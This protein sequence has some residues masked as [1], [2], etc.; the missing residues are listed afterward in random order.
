[1]LK[2]ILS[3]TLSII[4]CISILSSAIYA[5]AGGKEAA[6]A[7]YSLGLF[8]GIGNSPD[9]TPVYE[10]HRKPTRAEAITMLIR[11]LGKE[12]EA[13]ENI[14]P[15]PFTDV[16]DW[17][18]PYVSYAYWNGY[19]FGITE[20]AFGGGDT[21]TAPQFITFV[22]RALNYVSETDFKWDKAWEL[23]DSLG[24]TDGQ[25]NINSSEFTRG[26]AALIS[27]N[28]LSSNYKGSD[29][30]LLLSLLEMDVFTW[31]ASLASGIDMLGTQAPHTTLSDKSPP[32]AA[33]P[34]IN[35][36][37]F[38][39]RVLDLVNAERSSYGLHPLEWSGIAGSAARKHSQDMSD[40]DYFDHITPEG[41][42]PFQ[43]LEN[44]GPSLRY[45]HAG[46]NI[47]YGHLSPEG[48]VEGWMNS[49]GHRENILDPYYTYI[50]V[51]YSNNYWT[52]VFYAV[53]T[54]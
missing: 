2:R 40:R 11:L 37:D 26:D 52:Q 51:G 30:T 8:R 38:E 27:Y 28:A 10:L 1:M 16:E 5:S 53:F 47:A 54:Q 34:S 35:A 17:A 50:G 25:Y 43:R 31:E 3:T 36:A 13:L 22:L 42:D 41:V 48:V 32:L 21:V 23:S 39:Y 7:L 19:T 14:I 24:I 9:G 46:E 49:Q 45:S 18:L 4:I 44:E 20:T 12:A 15:T 33:L 6:D 29:K